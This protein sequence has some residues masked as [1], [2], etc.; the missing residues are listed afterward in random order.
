M[1]HLG[2]TISVGRRPGLA[3]RT[4]PVPALASGYLESDTVHFWQDSDGSLLAG[5]DFGS[6][7]HVG[8][9]E[10]RTAEVLRELERLSSR[11]TRLSAAEIL[12]RDRP[13]PGDGLPIVG[14]LPAASNVYI[15]VMHS[16]MTLAP[17][18]GKLV[19]EEVLN[20]HL[21]PLLSDYRPR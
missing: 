14:H 21:Q 10:R 18:I 4:C 11:P 9:P 6:A 13:M 16:G 3:V 19:A 20:E 2:A 8:A 1:A 5:A 12:V 17:L 15:A 7:G